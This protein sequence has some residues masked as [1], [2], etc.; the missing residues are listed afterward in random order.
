MS[1]ID[2]LDQIL[3]QSAAVVAKRLLGSTICRTINDALITAKIVETE[4]YDQSDLASHSN[5]GITPRTAVMFGPAGYWYIYSI[6]G[7]HFC[8]N[9]VTGTVGKGSAVL[10]RAVEPLTE[11]VVLN[12]YR[13]ASGYNVTNGPAK[14]CQALRI[15]KSLYGHDARQPPLKITLNDEL[16]SSS[17]TTTTRIG[18]SK[19][20]ST[21]WRF[22]ITGNPYV[23]IL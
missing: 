23:S 11:Q 6:Y 12:R 22:Y 19:A 7:M 1:N 14:L 3:G 9:L 13:A 2:E 15:D 20:Q 4:A 5:W 18:I 8:Y 17:V 10:I 21:P 16:S